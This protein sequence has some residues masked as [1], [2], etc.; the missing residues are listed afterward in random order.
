M[1]FFFFFFFSLV[2][3]S[4]MQ[5]GEGHCKESDLEAEP[6]QGLSPPAILTAFGICFIGCGLPR[7]SG[8]GV[9]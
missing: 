9:L 1:T 2:V 3:T 7:L 8:S 5:A 4:L 6:H